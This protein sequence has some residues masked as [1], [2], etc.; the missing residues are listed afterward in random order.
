MTPGDAPELRPASPVETIEKDRL[1]R[2]S[3]VMNL[4]DAIRR[5]KGGK[6]LTI[7]LHGPWGSGKN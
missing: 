7:G 6:S 4:A 3:F 5:Y 2:K 1:G